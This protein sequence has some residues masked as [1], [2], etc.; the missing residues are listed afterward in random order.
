MRLAH[1][2][3]GQ[4]RSNSRGCTLV[5]NFAF[6]IHILQLKVIITAYTC[7]FLDK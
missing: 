2:Q 7:L 6:E 5:N 4:L 3:G 1:L